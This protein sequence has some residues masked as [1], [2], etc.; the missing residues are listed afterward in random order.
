[1][2]T[3]TNRSK[4]VSDKKMTFL[5]KIYLP[6][7]AKGMFITLK[8]FFR[9]KSTISYP[10]QKR[11]FSE[12]YRGQHVLKR[13]ELGRERCTA[14]GLC[15]V[16]CPAEAITMIA[17]ERKPGE[18]NLYREEKYAEVY[19]INMLRCIFCG[20]C[21]EACPK[22]AIFL[23]DRIV[24]SQFERE[25]FIYGKEILVEPLDPAKRIDVSLRQTDAVLKFK[26]NKRFAHNK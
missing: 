26:E 12:I 24:A 13:D 23:T 2:Q 18:E 8:H 20:D 16:A 4:V 25:P 1:M 17:A 19:E 3:L 11:E 21:E 14:C 9:K 6:A 5:E 10:E 15:A 22:E 7:I